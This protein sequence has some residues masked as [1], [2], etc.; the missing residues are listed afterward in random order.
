MENHSDTNDEQNEVDLASQNDRAVAQLMNLAGL[1]PTIPAD[2]ERRVHAN[3]ISDWQ[4]ITRRQKTLRWSAT[5]ALAASVVLAITFALHPAPVSLQKLGS[6]ARVASTS[7]GQGFIVGS[8][9]HRGDTIATSADESL[10]VS[11]ANGLSLR[12]AEQSSIRFD[13]A[14]EFTLTQGQVYADSGQSIYRDH[15]IT[16]HTLAGSAT[17]IGTQFIVRYEDDNMSVAVREGRV[18]VLH[19]QD[20]YIAIAGEEL[21][22]QP[23]KSVVVAPISATDDAWS[24]AIALAP[25]FDID[26]QSLLDFLKWASREMG[27]ELVFA[28]DDLRMAAMGTILSGSVADFSPSEATRSVLATTQFEASI[29]DYQIV[30]SR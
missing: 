10:S 23:G 21:L 2:V 15:G 1:R 25:T 18:D 19:D 13:A 12:V 9:V 8:D 29:N 14:D 27:K 26:K 24:W 16:I 4:K 6:V 28:D 22:L 11:L 20:S 7:D 5:L 17:D 30:I 3:V